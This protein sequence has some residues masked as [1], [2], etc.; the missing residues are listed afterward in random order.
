MIELLLDSPPLVFLLPSFRE[1]LPLLAHNPFVVHRAIVPCLPAVSVDDL[2][3][4]RV[5][6]RQAL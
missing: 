4:G 2:Q 6:T 5:Y 1:G 3:P